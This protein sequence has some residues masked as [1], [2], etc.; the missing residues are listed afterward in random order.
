VSDVNPRVAWLKR[1]GGVEQPDGSWVAPP[2]ADHG[3]RVSAGEARALF[4]AEMSRRAQSVPGTMTF[5]VLER[6]H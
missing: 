1:M 6:K 2:Q 5:T 4:D 3:S